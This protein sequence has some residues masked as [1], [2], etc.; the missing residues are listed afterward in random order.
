DTT[1]SY[2]DLFQFDVAVLF[3]EGELALLDPD[4]R[5]LNQGVMEEIYGTAAS[6]GKQ[7]TRLDQSTYF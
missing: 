7:A 3:T 2:L 5:S 1:F 6:Q 4:Q